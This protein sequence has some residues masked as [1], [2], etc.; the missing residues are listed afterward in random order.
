MSRDTGIGGSFRHSFSALATQAVQSSR[1]LDRLVADRARSPGLVADIR[2]VEHEADA[3]TREVIMGVAKRFVPP[4]D[5]DEIT[6]IVRR[7]D[8]V[9]DI[10]DGTAQRISF[11]RDDPSPPGISALASTLVDSC[12]ALLHAV[13]GLNKLDTLPGYVSDIKLLEEKGDEIY[14]EG[15]TEL[16]SGT[17]DPL[18][19]VKWKDAYDRIEDAID[20]CR[21]AAQAIRAL[22]F[23]HNR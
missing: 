14:Y 5:S 1:L 18:H 22:V 16:F 15:L 3:V 2:D 17:P 8:D 13:D 20:A 7:L 19:V 12:E 4:T 10:I 6:A 21:A 9:I 23:K 11:F